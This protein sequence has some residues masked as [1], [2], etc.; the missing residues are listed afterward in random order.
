MLPTQAP[1]RTAVPE[2][3]RTW[4]GHRRRGL[5]AGLTL[6]L[7]CLGACTASLVTQ[8][9]A[10]G[11]GV[12]ANPA[13][14]AGVL[15]KHVRLLSE[16][17][18]PRDWTHQEGVATAAHYL[19]SGFQEVGGRVSEQT[20]QVRDRSFTNVVASFGPEVGPRVLVGAHYDVCGELPG[21][22]DNASGVAGLLELARLFGNSPPHQRVDLVAYTLE[23]P[24]FFRTQDMGSA[25]HARLMK[26]TWAEVKGV[27]ILEMIGRFTD[28]RHSQ[29]YPSVLLEPFYPDRGN[30]IAVVGRFGDIGLTRKVKAS[31]R[32]AM[33]LPVVSINGPRWI[34]GLDFSDHHPYWDQ[35]FKAVMV[36]DTSFYRNLDYHTDKDTA[37]RLD[38][39]RMAQVVQGVHAAVTRLG[40]RAN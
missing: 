4:E 10:P 19:K 36:T 3:Y 23:E 14:D 35:G 12:D 20:F 22:D 11:Q 1:P 30:F 9:M 13:V 31:M 15:E 2:A 21:A 38:Y 29:R 40:N 18:I 28:A 33:S 39:V 7:L 27:I 25:R 32:A 8:P 16:G 34:P 24:P 5:A 37:D 26:D 6:L 17:P